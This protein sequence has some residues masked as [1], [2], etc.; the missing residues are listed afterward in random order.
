[1][2]P[3]VASYSC[4]ELGCL[5]ENGAEHNSAA[6]AEAHT[7][8]H[9]HTEPDLVDHSQ[10]IRILSSIISTLTSIISTLASIISTS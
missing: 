10:P 2:G 5:L 6:D 1:M 4:T 8:T 7:H 9:T 3:S